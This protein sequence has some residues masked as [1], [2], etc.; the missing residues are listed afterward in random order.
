MRCDQYQELILTDYL[1]KEASGEEI[2][3]HLAGCGRCR[4]FA[5]RARKIALEPFE[6]IERI[7][8]SPRLWQNIKEAIEEDTAGAVREYPLDL[9]GFLKNLF[10]LPR[11]ALA[12]ATLAVTVV[13][14]L[15]LLSKQAPQPHLSRV[16]R[17]QVT[18]LASLMDDIGDAGPD[19][20]GGY[21]T[22]IEEYFL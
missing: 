18:H 3:R 10:P 7:S 22:V 17:E 12:V 15:T 11:P 6:H 4:E 16:D 2:E 20:N 19:E 13:M 1:D 8:P 5:E 9:W 14:V 21:G